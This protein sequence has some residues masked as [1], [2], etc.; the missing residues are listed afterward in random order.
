MKVGRYESESFFRSLLSP[1]FLDY[2]KTIAVEIRG[3]RRTLALL[4]ND[5]ASPLRVHRTS[6]FKV[7]IER[8]RPEQG[9]GQGLLRCALA[10]FQASYLFNEVSL[11]KERGVY[12]NIR[13]G[14]YHDG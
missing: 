14:R 8:T 2:I 7:R 9:E 12:I 5:S 10:F 4:Q 3:Q 1:D 6:R 13:R 11:Y